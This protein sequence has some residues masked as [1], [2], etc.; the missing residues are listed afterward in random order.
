[1][2][3]GKIHLSSK[4]RAQFNPNATLFIIVRGAA[5][6]GGRGP[7]IASAKRTGLSL[8]DF[9]LS[10]TITQQ[11]SMMGS[12]LTGEVKVS[13]RF[14]QDGDALSKEPGDL[15][16]EAKSTSVV[17]VNPVDVYVESAL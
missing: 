3:T 16:G 11:N 15:I 7:L 1:M 10:Y 12:P 17:G 8:S 13:A 6:Q 5:P 4:L 2:I 9:P 14:D